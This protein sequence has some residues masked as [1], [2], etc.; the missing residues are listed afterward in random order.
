MG[1]GGAGGAKRPKLKVHIPDEASDADGN[2]SNSGGQAGVTTDV[3]TSQAPRQGGV[4]LPPPSPS[5]NSILSAGASGP[6]NPFARPLPP[7]SNPSR[8]SLGSRDSNQGRDRDMERLET[9]VSALPSRFT[10]DFLPSPSSFYPEW[11]FRSGDMNSPLNYSLATPVI[12]GPSFARDE[13]YGMDAKPIAN[14]NGA[15]NGTAV[16]G[17][18]K[19]KSPDGDEESDSKRAK[20][21]T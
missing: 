7:Q 1:L 5:T 10:N 9:P 11:N 19:R 14:T 8:E 15:S 17:G 4:V 20:I 13:K 2:S 16:A 3:T 18:A 6:P 12:G 21:E